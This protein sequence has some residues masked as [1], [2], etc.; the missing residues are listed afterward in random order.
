MAAATVLSVASMLSV[1][2]TVGRMPVL[3][4]KDRPLPLAARVTF[5]TPGRVPMQE[6]RPP[7]RRDSVRPEAAR[8]AAQQE[9]L[10]PPG[11]SSL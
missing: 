3:E 9:T 1:F 7:A 4:P 10:Q 2:A 5:V 6:V 8:R 11:S